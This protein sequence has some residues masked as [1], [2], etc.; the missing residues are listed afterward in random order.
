MR[1]RGLMQELKQSMETEK[2]VREEAPG[3]N[4]P[5]HDLYMYKMCTVTRALFKKIVLFYE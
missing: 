1:G 2:M 4:F 5:W 3:L